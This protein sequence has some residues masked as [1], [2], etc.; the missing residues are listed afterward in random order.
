MLDGR[1][2]RRMIDPEMNAKRSWEA[3]SIWKMRMGSGLGYLLPILGVQVHSKACSSALSAVLGLED[4]FFRCVNKK[5]FIWGRG[6]EREEKQRPRV[7]WEK[8]SCG[9]H[10]GTVLTPAWGPATLIPIGT[11]EKRFETD[12]PGTHRPLSGFTYW[13]DQLLELG[14]RLPT[15]MAELT[16]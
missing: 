8:I 14:V 3:H 15:E 12:S 6:E 7:A 4:S 10:G 1:K 16:A 2:V 5:A 13:K 11:S 9:S